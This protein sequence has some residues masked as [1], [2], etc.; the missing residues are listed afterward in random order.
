MDKSP[1]EIYNSPKVADLWRMKEECHQYYA[2]CFNRFSQ[3]EQFHPLGF[4]RTDYP[5]TARILVRTL[6]F[7]GNKEVLS[8]GGKYVLRLHFNR[9]FEHLPIWNADWSQQYYIPNFWQIWE[10]FEIHPVKEV[11]VRKEDGKKCRSVIL[12][13]DKVI[14]MDSAYFLRQPRQ[15]YIEQALPDKL[16]RNDWQLALN[17]EISVFYGGSTPPPTASTATLL[18]FPTATK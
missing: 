10:T 17:R 16:Y 8:Q 5:N 13:D 6:H 2:N 18:T 3:G 9:H 11:I 12:A 15:S 14:Q 1:V 7:L 4:A